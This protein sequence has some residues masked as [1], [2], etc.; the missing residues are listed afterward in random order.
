MKLGM[1]MKMG[2]R[3]EMADE[4]EYLITIA[5]ILFT[6]CLVGSLGFAAMTTSPL[7]MY[8]RRGEMASHKT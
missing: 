5:T 2:M 4:C 8:P 3:M 6:T 7:L 1:G